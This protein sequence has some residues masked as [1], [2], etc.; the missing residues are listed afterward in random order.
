MLRFDIKYSSIL[1]NSDFKLSFSLFNLYNIFISLFTISLS[2][3]LPLLN[4]SFCEFVTYIITIIII[5]LLLL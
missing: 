4:S 5:I 3:H 2:F 1:D